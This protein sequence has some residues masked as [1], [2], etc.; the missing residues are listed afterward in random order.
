MRPDIEVRQ[1]SP[2]TVIAG[3]HFHPEAESLHQCL[4]GEEGQVV[5]DEDAGALVNWDMPMAHGAGDRISGLTA[6]VGV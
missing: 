5:L 3:A 4:S 1:I 6:S 2:M